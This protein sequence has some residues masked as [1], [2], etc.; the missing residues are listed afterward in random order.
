MGRGSTLN[1]EEIGQLKAFRECGLN[2][3]QIA[4]KINRSRKVITNYL[5]D[6][7]NYGKHFKGGIKTA[8]TERERRSIL[9][10]AS[11]SAFSAAKIRER[12]GC[13]SSIRTVQR[14]LKCAKHLQRRKMLKKPVLKAIHKEK[15]LAFARH[16]MSWTKEW[17]KVIFTDEKK[18][19]LDGPDGFNYYFHDL[20]KEERILGR[21]HS[22]TGSVMVWGAISYYGTIDLAFKTS[23]MTAVTYKTLL[24]NA[25]PK[26]RDIFHTLPFICQQD[27]APIH[28][29][30]IVK[31]WINSQNVQLIEWPPYSPDLNIIENVWGWL[32]RKVYEN[33]RQ[34][35]SK[36]DLTTAIKG[37]WR[38][39]SL[40]YLKEL[41]DSMPN[42]CYEVITKSGGNTHY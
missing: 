29:A 28:T 15:R 2:I 25:F 19:N 7:E 10:I 26:C 34:F 39:I 31:S 37:A 38:Q 9:K 41:Y 14:I 5:N 24:E 3:S 12:A 23:T 33:G 16:H 40:N 36:E 30:R 35:E 20:R 17:H 6:P 32:A 22:R 11:N 18:F 21:H 42:R 4:S 1:L 8:T 13:T 27:N